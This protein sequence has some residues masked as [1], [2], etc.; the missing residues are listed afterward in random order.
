MTVTPVEARRVERLSV[1]V[2]GTLKGWVEVTIG[3]KRAGRVLKVLHDMGDKI[4][5]GERLIEI[6]AIDADLSVLRAERMLQADLAKLGLKDLPGREFDPNKVPAVVQAQ[7]ALERAQLDLNR[8]RNLVSRN[9]GT[10]QDLQNA[11]NA[12][13]GQAAALE[14]AVLTARSTLATALADK[15]SLDSTTQA[16]K[17][18]EV[19][20]PVPSKRPKGEN[21]PIEYAV[22]RKM[23]HEGQWVKEGE[24][25]YDLVIASPLRIWTNVP[26]RYS[27][28]VKLGQTVRL[29]VNSHQGQ[30]FE[31]AGHEDQPHGRCA[32]PHVPGRGPASQPRRSLASGRLRQGV[33]PHSTRRRGPGRAARGDRAVRG[34]DQGVRRQRRPGA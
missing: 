33:Y 18:M 15:A 28:D 10:Q 3:A 25:L 22:A 21:G 9:A 2:V 16:R 17:D 26:E 11:E 24:A 34:S 8:Q 23:V 14:N 29:A 5:P 12:E 31:W 6:E 1:E 13:Q 27:A 32:E 19:F 20:A 30:F 7:V 4:A